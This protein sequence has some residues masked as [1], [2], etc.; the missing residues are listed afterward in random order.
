MELS[1]T[2][3]AWRRP[4]DDTAT[5]I[6]DALQDAILSVTPHPDPEVERPKGYK[7]VLTLKDDS[8]DL[9]ENLQAALMDM[10]PARMTIHLEGAD[11][12]VEDL[13]VSVSKVPYP[14]EQNRA[15]LGVKPEGHDTLY[16]SL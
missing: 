9:A 10:D 3:V 7:V 14:G 16:T 2:R 11:A 12:P 8:T 6:T 13:P 1:I 4:G 5:D 15:E